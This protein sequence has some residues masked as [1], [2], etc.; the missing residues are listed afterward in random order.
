MVNMTMGKRF[1]SNIYNYVYNIS[2]KLMGGYRS[3]NLSGKLSEHGFKVET[4][5][6]IQQLLFPSEVIL[7]HK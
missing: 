6:Y 1:G 4:R 3:V 5:E 2:P 7:A